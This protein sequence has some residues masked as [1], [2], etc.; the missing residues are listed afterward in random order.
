[1]S[2][3]QF[4][5]HKHGQSAQDVDLMD[6]ATRAQYTLGFYPVH[7]PVDGKY[8]RLQ[9]KVSRPGVTVLARDGY[10]AR[11]NVGAVE[12]KSTI[13]L[14]RV[15]S[16]AG[17]PFLIPDIGIDKLTLTARAEPSPEATVSMSI[18]LSRVYFEKRA[19]LNV[20]SIDVGV[21]VVTNRDREAGQVWH[22]L[23]LSYTDEELD[24][25]RRTGLLHESVVPLTARPEAVKVVVY[26]YASDLLG[27]AV[28]RVARR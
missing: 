11:A 21:F 22:N 8:R 20:A 7:D 26:D 10:Y 5:A 6:R 1:L 28:A 9:V 14:S 18:D 2:G 23:A 3:G 13:V 25:R 4:F 12:M 24:E 16:A 17:R 27:S 15:R 19:G